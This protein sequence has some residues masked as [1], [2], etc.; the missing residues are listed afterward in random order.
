MRAWTPF[1]D[2]LIAK[3]SLLGLA[4][5]LVRFSRPVMEEA[6]GQVCAR[7]GTQKE[8][9]LMLQSGE[10]ENAAIGFLPWCWTSFEK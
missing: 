4:K 6:K 10:N 1:L 5:K 3:P 9:R 8:L 2:W 7:C